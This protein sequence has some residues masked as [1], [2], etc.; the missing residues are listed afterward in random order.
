MLLVDRWVAA[1]TVLV[2]LLL[3]V[4]PFL[5]NPSAD[6]FPACL[7]FS[8]VH[9]WVPSAAMNRN[10]LK[11]KSPLIGHEYARREDMLAVAVS[12]DEL[13]LMLDRGPPSCQGNLSHLT[14]TFDLDSLTLDGFVAMAHPDSEGVAACREIGEME[15]AMGAAADRRTMR[16]WRLL[17]SEV[18]R[19]YL[20]AFGG[21]IGSL[22]ANE[23]VAVTMPLV[24]PPLVM[25]FRFLARRDAPAGTGAS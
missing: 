12:A 18:R 23:I 17:Y 1:A 9:Y 10:I 24:L 7:P 15:V 11:I 8:A 2:S 6:S 4:R 14:C 3:F 13:R 21:Q 16:H 5:S 22:R 20:T 19:A 25:A